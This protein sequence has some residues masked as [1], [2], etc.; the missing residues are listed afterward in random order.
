MKKVFNFFAMAAVVL[1]LGLS[2]CAK[3]D[4]AEPLDVDLNRTAVLKGTIL[5]NADIAKT[6]AD[7]KLSAPSIT[8]DAFIVTLSYSD[9]NS[10]ATG[11][12]IL[13]K[14]KIEY[15][16]TGE[17]TITAP[18]GVGETTITVKVSDFTG[19]LKKTVSGTDKTI[20]VIWKGSDYAK[21]SL[22]VVPGQTSY[23][24][25]WTL[26]PF[27]VPDVAEEVKTDGSSAQ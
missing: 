3:E 15:K 16:S 23:F 14:D 2:G 27:M 4:P 19:T 26:D 13:P 21:G 18:V 25:T 6:R 20:D 22:K 8:K 24:D 7:Q 9:L 5:I 11:T 12:Y 1:S 17:F 10:G